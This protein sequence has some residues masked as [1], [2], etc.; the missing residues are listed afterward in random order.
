VSWGKTRPVGNQTPFGVTALHWT[1]G[2]LAQSSTDFLAI[3]FG[4]DEVHCCRSLRAVT[5]VHPG[6]S[7]HYVKAVVLLEK[8]VT[9]SH[10]PVTAV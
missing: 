9:P 8:N 4:F 6:Q 3:A 1:L 10:Q 2:Q 7:L 5:R